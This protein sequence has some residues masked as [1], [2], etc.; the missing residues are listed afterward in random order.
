RSDARAS[1]AAP[2]RVPR[3]G[4]NGRGPTSTGWTGCGGG[5]ASRGRRPWARR[6]SAIPDAPS[7]PSPPCPRKESG[8]YRRTA[9][10]A[11]MA[12]RW[13]PGLR[14]V[15]AA[16]RFDD[17]PRLGGS[18]GSGLVF[19]H[20]PDV[21]QDRSNHAPLR[22]DGVLARK[23]GCVAPHRIS[24]KALVGAHLVGHVLRG[25]E[26]DAPSRH[27]LSGDLRPHAERD[28]DVG[29]ETKS[30]EVRAAQVGEGFAEHRSRRRFQLDEHF[31]AGDRQALAGAYVEG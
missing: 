24:K 29:S 3:T 12:S 23:E 19:V 30:H 7:S 28:G 13:P 11:P 10:R 22:L 14:F 6:P 1:K 31:G 8:W 17:S 5:S 16:R 21:A 2:S 4:R 27:R 15:P 26:L 20:R 25:E 9:D 18:P